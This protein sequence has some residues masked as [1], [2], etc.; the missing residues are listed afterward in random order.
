[1]GWG[2]GGWGGWGYGGGYYNGFNDGYY[3]GSYGGF[4]TARNVTYGPRSSMNRY[5]GSTRAVNS[6]TQATRG[7]LRQGNTQLMTEPRSNSASGRNYS[8]STQRASSG[9]SAT[10]RTTPAGN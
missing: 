4:G 7:Q 3:A 6:R 10:Q 8:R 5:P 1:W 2:Y 9:G